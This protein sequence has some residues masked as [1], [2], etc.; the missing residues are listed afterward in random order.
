MRQ[1]KSVENIVPST[2]GHIYSTVSA[3]ELVSVSHLDHSQFLEVPLY[4]FQFGV[5][6]EFLWLDP[7]LHKAHETYALPN[8]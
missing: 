6:G 5:Q 4:L 2:F 7:S 1:V 3:K 8:H